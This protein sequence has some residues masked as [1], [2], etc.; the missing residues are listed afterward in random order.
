MYVC[1]PLPRPESIHCM[2]LLSGSMLQQWI[3]TRINITFICPFLCLFSQSL[4]LFLICFSCVPLCL[5]FSW[6]LSPPLGLSLLLCLSP[7]LGPAP[8]R[9][10]RNRS[11]RL[12]SA[13]TTPRPAST[14]GSVPWSTTPS[15]G[16]AA[17]S[18]RARP[19]PGSSAWAPA[20]ATGTVPKPVSGLTHA[21]YTWGRLT[22]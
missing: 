18:R 10:G 22:D 5:F 21:G 14:C 3:L 20:S 19:A 7:S 17:P 4:S 9:R 13:W 16:C 2:F 15:S 8:S 1:P 12:C 11:T 6:S